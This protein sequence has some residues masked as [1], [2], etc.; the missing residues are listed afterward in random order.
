MK[1]S[2]KACC[3]ATLVALGGC[4]QYP[5]ERQGGVDHRP[6]ISFRSAGDAPP[7]DARVLVDGLDA[8]RVG[9]FLDGQGA[10]RV[11]PGSHVIQI[12]AGGRVVHEER[13]YLADGV[14]RAL[15]LP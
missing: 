10:L 8:G 1:A 14:S 15:N 2:L 3:L 12:V 11:L 4:V 13:I 5:T 6:Q 7:V 9:D